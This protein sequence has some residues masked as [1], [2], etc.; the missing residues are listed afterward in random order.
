MPSRHKPQSATV[1]IKPTCRLRLLFLVFLLVTR[2]LGQP[3]MQRPIRVVIDDNYPPFAFADNEGKPQG[4]SVD[5]WRLWERKTGIRVDLYALDWEEA[6]KRMRAGEFDVLG[7]VFKTEARTAY[8]DFTKPYSRVNVPIFFRREIVGINDIKSLKGFPVAVKEG[9]AAADLL[10]QNGIDTL[11]LFNTYEAIVRAAQQ[12]KVNV[13]VIDE[14][15]AL[16]F[17][18]KL[19]IEGDFRRSAPINTGELRRAVKKGDPFL[20][21]LEAGF[22]GLEPAA[23][24][25]LEYKWYG[26]VIHGRRGFRYLGYAAVVSLMLAMGF[27]LRILSLRRLVKL[28]T[29]SLARRE[30]DLQTILRTAHDGFVM[31]DNQ[32]RFLEVNASTCAMTG[33]SREEMLA[34]SIKDLAAGR[35][36]NEI[37]ARL[38]HV[39]EHDW[40]AFESRIRRKDGRMVD[41]EVSV[42]FLN[43]EGGRFF[44]FVRD[45]TERHHAAQQQHLAHERVRALAS[46]LQSLRE[47]ERTRIAREIHDHL[48]QLLTALK[49]D[50]HALKRKVSGMS[51]PDLQAALTGKLKSAR[52]LTDEVVVSVQKIALELR[53]GSLDRLGLTAAV[54][55]ETQA[56]QERTGI[57]CTG[58][59]PKELL[60]LSQDEA[61]SVFRVFQEILTNIARHAHAT[62]VTIRL[63]QQP[64][65][66]LLEVDDNGIGLRP[67][68]I[69]SPKSLGL[70]G[71]H[72]RAA[73]LC[74]GISFRPA[75]GRG[76]R[77]TLQ[78]PLQKK[79]GCE[80]CTKS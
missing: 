53:P 66:L 38:R 29:D 10:R 56:F 42:N 11:L 31:A 27:G 80:P 20:E 2:V 21:T 30:L 26:E 40:A 62:E 19:G 6:V 77:V 5:E 24:R 49:L 55:A 59:L 15:S 25:Q 51:A 45:I 46:R 3:P 76:T 36:E 69:E 9:D 39:R 79:E 50:L 1:G 57:R 34:R 22:D 52:D 37:A 71:M 63:E 70:L 35:P 14:P 67:G 8:W 78:I 43:Q 58:F 60:P 28:R 32:G 41:L 4:L 16:Y 72:E 68:D 74:G 48:G 47:E 13:F 61:T 65:K 44:A 64:D 17:L 23:L 73:I 54:E 33:Y 75:P 12:H 18:H 7:T